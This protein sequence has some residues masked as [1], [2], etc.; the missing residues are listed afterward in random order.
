MNKLSVK[1]IDLLTRVK[2]NTELRTLFFRKV[3]GLKWFD[4]FENNGY[5]DPENLPK[6]KQSANE[7]YYSIADWDIVE[8]LLKTAPSLS[9]E[10]SPEYIDKFINIMLETTTY[11]RKH[12]L[13]NYRVWWKFIQIL[14]HFPVSVISDDIVTSID[15]WLDDK[16]ETGIS[17]LEIGQKWF[18]TLI[19]NNNSESNL[20]LLKLIKTLCNLKSVEK[21]DYLDKKIIEFEFR[22]RGSIASEIF[23]THAIS[24]GQQVGKEILCLLNSN[25][26]HLIATNEKDSWSTI[27]QPAIED[28]DQNQYHDKTINILVLAFRDSL[29][30]FLEN[31]QD[32]AKQYISQ[33]LS[34]ELEI[35]QRIA[36]F[37]VSKLDEIDCS[38]LDI[39]ITEKYFNYNF[40]HEMWCFLNQKYEGFDDAYKVEV[41]DIISKILRYDDNGDLLKEASAYAQSRWFFAIKNIGLK[42]KAAYEKS[43]EISGVEPE[44]PDFLSYS[45]GGLVTTTSPFSANELASF[46]I[47]ELIEKLSLYESQGGYPEA[48]VEGLSNALKDVIKSDPSKYYGSLNKFIALDLAYNYAVIESF[49]D[50]AIEDAA[51]PWDDVWKLLLNYSFN[52]ISNSV[53]WEIPKKRKDGEFSATPDWIVTSLSRMINVGVDHKSYAFN[54]GHDEIA[55]RIIQH[56][57][58]NQ[59][60][61]KFDLESDAVAIAINSPR[62]HCLKAL[63]H[64]ALKSFR[65]SKTSKLNLESSPWS[66]FEPNF[67]LELNNTE[68]YNYEFVTLVMNYLPNFLFMN[69]DWLLGNLDKI[70]SEEDEVKWSCAMQGYSYVSSVQ[71]ELYSY[72]KENKHFERALKDKA[73]P[74]HVSKRII[75]Q[76]AISYIYGNE[77]IDDDTSMIRQLLEKC[78]YDHISEIIWFIWT[79]R[80]K[81]ISNIESKVMI[82]WDFLR[83]FI[84]F[85]SP[86][87]KKIA[88]KLLLFV[89][90]IEELTE[91]NMEKVLEIAQFASLD[92]NPWQL[93][94]RLAV[95]SKKSPLEAGDIWLKILTQSVPIYPEEALIETFKN[96]ALHSSDG[97]RVAKEIC[98]KYL[99]SGNRLLQPVLKSL[100]NNF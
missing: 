96:I 75:Q 97:M 28:H 80:E 99:I 54:E 34:S 2:K 53:F 14:S 11:A 35:I 3:V 16:F 15:Y 39:L 29:V 13:Y 93:T 9:L 71:K 40:H 87:G 8:Y 79:L 90:F 56:L 51:L 45:S 100:A 25:L 91:K 89:D 21:T 50:L 31:N 84:D 37:G 20:L 86:E 1:E 76:I 78:E 63:I 81:K 58:E 83:K 38:V 49:A 46:S 67:D 82:L 32:C 4:S 65:E 74:D 48:G 24:L 59:K 43:V 18:T 57:L 68:N 52:L 70:F 72:L 69:H 41:L 92:N 47:E 27:W 22:F 7:G 55:F 23:K 62:G 19:K 95:L 42:E 17:A 30:G 12:E 26:E 73:I 77:E 10:E 36:I 66:K 6:P 94:E 88:S 61:E 5:F 33:L 98:G 85:N 60:G 44:H 64:L